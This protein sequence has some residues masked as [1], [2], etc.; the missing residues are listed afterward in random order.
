[1]TDSLMRLPYLSPSVFEFSLSAEAVLCT[2]GPDYGNNGK[3]GDDLGFGDF[4]F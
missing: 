4:N 3:P 1:M 2:S